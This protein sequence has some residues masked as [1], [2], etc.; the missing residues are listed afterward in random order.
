MHSLAEVERDATGRPLRIMGTMHDVTERK[1]AE[2][3]AR[4]AERQLVTLM[5]NYPD[6]V[7]RYDADGRI[8]YASPAIARAMNRRTDELL[9]RTVRDVAMGESPRDDEALMA[10]IARVAATGK[11][12]RLD[13]RL[14]TADGARDFEVRHVA[15]YDERG[16]IASV[17]GIASDL[18][19]RKAAARQLYILN[20][21]LDHVSES[22]FLVEG[23]A[24]RFT[25]ANQSAADRLGYRRDELSGGMGVPDIDPA[26]PMEQWNA[27]LPSLR[28]ARQVTL[29]TTHRT[30][31]GRDI[32][33]EITS[34]TF[35]F[36]GQHYLMGI[37]RDI[38]ERRA[39]EA[40]LRTR[41][42]QLRTLVDHTPDII[43]RLDLDGRYLFANAMMERVTG[44]PV[45]RLI[46]QPIE[47]MSGLAESTQF[48]ALLEAMDALRRTGRPA[49]LE[50]AVP[51]A[52]GA[53]EFNV[54]LVPEEDADGATSTMMIVARDITAQKRAEAN[55]RASE[56]RF[57]QVTE[58]IDEVFWLV[59]A[60]TNT[61][62]YVSPAYPRV[63]GRSC[64]SFYAVPGAWLATIHPDDVERFTAARSSQGD[65]T[66]DLEY[67]IL[68]D[69][70]VAWIRD[71]AFP[72]RDADGHTYLIAGV[73]EDVT[74]RRGLE[75]RLRQAQ[76]MEAI[77]QLAGGI[78]HD[79]NNMLAIIQLQ[80]DLLLEE[81]PAA[82]ESREGLREI[83]TV[84]QRAANLTRQLLTFSRQQVS[85]LAPLDLGE[86]LGSTTKL[87]RRIL[88]EDVSL[89]TR[90]ASELPLV[91]AD[92]GMMEQVLMNL[93]INARDAMPHGGHLT[94]DV[95][96]L[97]VSAEQAALRPDH[98]PG[99]Y[100]CLSVSDT[101]EGIAAELLPRIFDPFFTTKDVGKGTGLGLAT[102]FGIMQ[103]H[104]GWID[105]QSTLGVGTTFRACLPALPANAAVSG[106]PQSADAVRGGRE[107]IL[108]VEDEAMLRSVTRDMLERLGYRVLTADT[109]VQAVATWNASQGRI[110][111]L[112]TDLVMPGGRTGRQLAEELLAQAPTLRVLFSTG[113]S[114][115][116]VGAPLDLRAGRGLLQ[117][118]YT[119]AGLARAVRR[120]LDVGE[121]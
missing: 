66:L 23:D 14:R 102:V 70:D 106:E 38:S 71:R 118:P 90:F 40:A 36:E 29:D 20:Y 108:L 37:A 54:R 98:P 6:G 95:A 101:G 84:T 97:T 88:G 28:K 26:W 35:E 30:R 119:A 45:E 107:T 21:A 93:A 3:T 19:E 49:E 1:R 64:E 67:R 87:L 85:Q 16:A 61:G 31:D 75:D 46:G 114:P 32:P 104:G 2:E 33:I 110:D 8:R 81:D 59:D 86:V 60:E 44:V 69:G 92:A 52:S 83:L 11:G 27:L 116:V 58:A 65:G 79:F 47:C 51:L 68:R 53:R 9:G 72:I 89:T 10:S 105:V 115:D 25:Y 113:Y 34:N 109:A 112:M 56:Q 121:G 120:V 96:P 91:N 5:E 22:I 42:L 17:L 4:A 43:L 63:F 57:R 62:V 103:Q 94:V 41:E 82:E 15:E 24:P 13:V 55:L 12:E 39:A 78:A 48:G 74:V 100:V 77:G 18:T 99:A 76:K 73:A 117:K 50:M 80:S 111:L 7:S